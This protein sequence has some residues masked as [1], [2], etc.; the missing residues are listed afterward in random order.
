[1]TQQAEGTASGR[2]D[3]ALEQ[4]SQAEAGFSLV[5]PAYNEEHGIGPVLETLCEDLEAKLPGVPFEV[6]VVDDGSTDGTAKA[7]EPL[8]GERLRLVRSEVNRGY[9]G[10]IKKG[11][12]HTQYDWIAITDADGTYPNEE[13][14]RLLAHRD[15]YEM[16]VGARTGHKAAVPLI[17][18]PAK[19]VLRR[20]ASFLVR[21]EIPDLNSG[22][23]VMG[24]ELFLRNRHLLPD[25]FS[26]TTTI[27]LAALSSGRPVK[28]LSIN[29]L[30][31]TG[32]SKIRP[33]ADTLNFVMLILRTIVYFAPLRVFLP[34]SI[35]FGVA[36]VMV[37]GLSLWLTGRVMDVT[38]V[39]LFLTGIHLFALGLI[40][41]LLTRR[42]S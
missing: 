12:E 34:L 41:D 26:L 32:R 27:T 36:S 6:I 19:W 37:A 14:V 21:Y 7:V 11:A 35:G 15:R 25:G 20:L 33:I 31:R 2:S 28:Y 10:A 16:I 4:A 1:M 13:L 38:T 18:R 8:V 22:L 40:A 30:R 17:R 42:H 39:L 24:K 23:R 9:G 29:Y 5:I 3:S